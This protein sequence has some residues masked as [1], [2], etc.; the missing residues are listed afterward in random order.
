MVLV[1]LERELVTL[2]AAGFAWAMSVCR[3]DRQEAEDVLQTAYMKLL[4]GSAAPDGRATLKTFLFAVIR[5]TAQDRRRRRL[6]T[7]LGLLRLFEAPP[8]PPPGPFESADDR[9]RQLRVR[10]ALTALPA[11]QREVIDLVSFTS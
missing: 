2:H 11:R 7:T 8:D 3:F 5:R 4:D 9:E 6:V 10:R 1:S